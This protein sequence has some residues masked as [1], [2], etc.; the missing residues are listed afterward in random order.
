[1][2]RPVHPAAAQFAL[3]LDEQQCWD[4]MSTTP[5]GRLAWHGPTG[6]TVVPVNY[7]V[8]DGE[9]VVRTTAYSAAARECDDSVVSFQVDAIDLSS[10]SGWSV[11]IRGRAH[12]SVAG[13]DDCVDVWPA[14]PRPYVL[15]IDVHEVTGRRL[16]AL[17]G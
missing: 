10:R 8:D 17:P 6:I 12:Q 9:V 2:S 16:N 14:G 11:L 15:R 1:M 3:E 7:S 13:P 5:V 4:L